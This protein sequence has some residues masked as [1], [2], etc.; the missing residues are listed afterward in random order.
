MR[1]VRDQ[2]PVGQGCFNAGTIS[3]GG[4]IG[5]ETKHFRYVYDCGSSN[6]RAMRAAIDRC[7][8]Q[9]SFIDALFVS[10]LDDDHVS[11]LDRLLAAVKVDSVYIPYVD[12]L[13]PILDLLEAEK[14]TALSVSLIEATIDPESW[15]GRRGVKRVIRVSG[16][17]D[18]P[19]DGP[20]IPFPGEP[21]DD[22]IPKDAS[23]HFKELPYAPRRLRRG[24][25][26]E[27]SELLQ[28]EPGDS[29]AIFAANRLLDWLLLPYVHPAPRER[30]VAFRKAMRTTLDLKARQR[31]TATRLADALRSRH[32]RELL[33]ECYDEII[34]GGARRMHNRISMSLYSGP[35]G[36][37]PE[38]TWQRQV[39]T[40]DPIRRSHWWASTDAVGW[41]GTGDATLNVKSVRTAWRKA[42][43]PLESQVSTLLLPHHGSRHNFHSELLDPGKLTLCVAS[44]GNPS[45]YGHPNHRVIDEIR[46]RGKNFW[47]VSQHVDSGITE[48]IQP[49]QKP[50]S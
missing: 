3:F 49:L 1:I 13:V 31:L 9:T 42:Y 20:Y 17:N 39:E 21:P 26:G 48:F 44:A 47:H 36:R 32:E 14:E 30:R 4:P 24:I 28:M 27:R 29:I 41:L 40:Y 37:R 22:P 38:Q 19:P 16:G 23:L 12:N 43:E 45:R 35:T 7:K 33:R 5:E 11:G 15:F 18:L 25:T 10:H 8:S 6:Q 50:Y 2:Y 34:A 46:A